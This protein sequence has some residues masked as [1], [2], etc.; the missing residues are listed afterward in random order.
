VGLFVFSCDACRWL[1]ENVYNCGKKERKP[2]CGMLPTA[3]AALSLI[4]RN[5]K[6][7]KTLENMF[8]P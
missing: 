2:F 1:C 6:L 5:L 4:L 7:D 8:S 3:A